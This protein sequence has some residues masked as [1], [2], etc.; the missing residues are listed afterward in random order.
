MQSCPCEKKQGNFDF[1][2]IYSLS[3][4]SKNKTSDE[5]HSNFSV[6]L[7]TFNGDILPSLKLVASAI[8]LRSQLRLG[9]SQIGIALARIVSYTPH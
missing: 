9:R 5:V 1:C 2:L 8:K 4:N 6:K 3:K 7:L